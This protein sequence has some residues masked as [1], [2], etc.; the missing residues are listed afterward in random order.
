MITK[1]VEYEI[2]DA[3]YFQNTDRTLKLMFADGGMYRLPNMQPVA[4]T[5]NEDGTFS[6]HFERKE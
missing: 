3:Q 4:F 2:A 6:V 1:E 5:A